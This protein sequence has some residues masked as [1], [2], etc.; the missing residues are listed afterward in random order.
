MTALG[1]A[2]VFS[3]SGM[4]AN[5]SGWNGVSLMIPSTLTESLELLHLYGTSFN[6]VF[7]EADAVVDYSIGDQS[8]NGR[9]LTKVGTTVPGT[10]SFVSDV[11]NYYLSPLTGGDLMAL[12]SDGSFTAFGVAKFMSLHSTLMGS[13]FSNINDGWLLGNCTSLSSRYNSMTSYANGAI[14]D[15]TTPSINTDADTTTVYEFLAVVYDL[16]AMTIKLYRQK[17]GGTLQASSPITLNA[18]FTPL[19]RIVMG[20]SFPSPSYT[21]GAELVLN[22]ANSKAASATEIANL[23]ISLKAFL[24]GYSVTI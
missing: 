1:P 6:T 20:T 15:Q 7:P 22:G 5:H 10:K 12:S 16:T 19:Q 18:T 9:H 23:Q 4:P 21:V 13:W 17:P 8:H 2:I 11:D 14:T 3:G 24:A